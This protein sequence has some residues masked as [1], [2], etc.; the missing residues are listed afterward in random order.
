VPPKAKA[1]AESGA[2]P[3]RTLVIVESPAKAKTIQGYLGPGY[4]VEASVGHIRDLPKRAADI[5]AKY[6]GESWSRLG[7]D[8]D[9]GYSAL[10]VVD[11]DKR[12]KVAELKKKLAEADTLLLATDEDREGE[13]IAWHLL[14]VLAPKV[15]VRRMVFHEITKDAIQRAVNETRELDQD[16]V[17]AQET[18]RILDRLYGYEVSPVLWK[19]VM[20]G[21]SAGRVQSV[22]TRLVVD[23]ERERI[24]FRSA[25]YWDV[26]GLFDPG[27]FSAKL[28]AVD[29]LRVATGKDFSDLGVL[30]RSDA[31]HLTEETATSL[32]AGLEGVTFTVRS[33]EDKPYRR[34]PAAPFMT[35]TL[36][37]EASRKMRWGAQRTMRVA[38]GLYERGYITY[39]RTDSTTLS[40]SAVNAARAQA[41][42]LYG[43]D[44]V[45]EVPRRYDRKVKNAQ[46][47]HEAVRPAGDTFRTPAE[48]AGE[49][50]GDEFALYDLIWKRTVASQMADARGQTAT[51][52]LG[53]VA[54]DGRDAEFSVSGTVITF[55]GF[56]AAYEESVDDDREATD[57][58]TDRRLPPLAVGD[59][60][61]ALRL[62]PEGHAT[63]PPPRY[64][65]ASL[66]KALEERGIGR[67]STYA[68]ILGT[69]VD[70]GYVVK[71][72]SA[73]VPSFLAF[74][75][76]RLMEEHFTRLVDYDFTARL[77]EILDT[78]ASGESDRV[79]VLDRF[80]RGGDGFAGLHPLVND[81]GEIDAREISSFPILDS[82]IVL[83]VGRYGPYVERG[84]ERANV[85]VELAPDELT[86]E[87]AEELLALPSGDHHLGTDPTSGREVVAKTGRYGPYVT[88]ILEDDAPKSARPRTAS[89]FTDMAI[90]TIDLET[91]LSLLSLPRE[92]GADPSDGVVITAQN[93]RYGPYI[94]KDKDSRSLPSEESIFTVTLE[95]ALAI[96]AQ[97]KQRRGQAA[98]KPGI[99]VGVDPSTNREVQL[100]EGRFGPYVT[101]GETNASLR[102]ADDPATISIERAADLLAERRAKDP[103][104]KK[105][106]AKRAPA[107]KS[108]AKKAPAKKPAAKKTTAKKPAPESGGSVALA[109]PVD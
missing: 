105:K 60:L 2:A 20:T 18:R 45:S 68:S 61:T 8:V 82:D 71:R 35:S 81:L 50:R 51:I 23:R 36:Q 73:L 25:S 95:E 63:N 30:T 98:P 54:S 77:E 37:Q 14:E 5:P 56:L 80:Y 67:P 84:D 102:R 69:I 7:V 43:A 107:K 48:V 106:A 100:K 29:G 74:A 91:A 42:Q 109:D 40:E 32:A 15:P 12:T 46:E 70:R 52:R 58:D 87:K 59:A 21:L 55:R 3:G 65:E 66:V 47:A 6:K 24:A 108:S 83:R 39:M 75:V 78:V 92:V 49:L 57:D 11:N 93:G 19:K 22:A 31:A 10:Y 27:S 38:Q 85:P 101:D 28:V 76:V 4:D 99:V 1:T 9:H 89:L 64:T 44:H 26:E 90:D 104:P 16:L 79:Q 103:A 72:G 13:A 94:T 88:E 17:D 33:V 41:A 86:R 34:S 96:L 53:A 97:P 62:D